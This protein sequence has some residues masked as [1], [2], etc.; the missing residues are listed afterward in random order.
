M[1]LISGSNGLRLPFRA[2]KVA[3]VLLPLAS[4]ARVGTVL[5]SSQEQPEIRAARVGLGPGL[6]ER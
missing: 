2:V 1:L 6:S 3:E 5:A 4:L